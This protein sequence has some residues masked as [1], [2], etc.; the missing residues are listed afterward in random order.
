MVDKISSADAKII[1][2]DIGNKEIQSKLGITQGCISN[3]KRRGIPK[4]V[5]IFLRKEYPHLK[6]WS[7][8]DARHPAESTKHPEESK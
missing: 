5:G 8:I 2:K 6:A 4:V 1:L 7:L 3:W